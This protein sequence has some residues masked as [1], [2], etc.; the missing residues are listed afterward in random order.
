MELLRMTADFDE[1]VARRA[2]AREL[3]N[4]ARDAGFRSLVDDGMRRVLQ[5]VTTIDEIS[6]VVDLTDRLA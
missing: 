5:G 4:A 2:P 3:R 6:R 1:L